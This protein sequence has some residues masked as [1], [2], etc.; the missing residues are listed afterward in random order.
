MANALRLELRTE[1]RQTYKMV[2]LGYN[3]NTV[4]WWENC[5]IDGL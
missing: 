5:F 4:S 2:I 3:N 1:F